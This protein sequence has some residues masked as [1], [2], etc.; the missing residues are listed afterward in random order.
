MLEQNVPFFIVAGMLAAGGLVVLNAAPPDTGKILAQSVVEKIKAAHPEITGLE[1]AAARSEKEGCKTIAATEAGEVGQKC[2][3]DELAAMKTN[4]PFVEQEEKE[5]DATL[6]L[7]DSAGKV[8]G[9]A[10]MDFKVE[11]GQTKETV[12]RQAQRIVA[13]LEKRFTSKEQLFQPAK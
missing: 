7:H 12:T 3:Q 10:G 6:P 5:F 13:E 2:D 11:P 1:V 9:T 4:A 8:I